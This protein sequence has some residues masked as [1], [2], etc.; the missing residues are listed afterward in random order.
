MKK[1]RDR[2]TN[3]LPDMRRKPHVVTASYQLAGLMF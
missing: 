3:P 1:T 2:R